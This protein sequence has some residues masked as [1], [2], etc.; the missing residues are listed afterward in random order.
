MGKFQE[1][2]CLLKNKISK[3]ALKD[4][5]ICSNFN[6]VHLVSNKCYKIKRVSFLFFC[7]FNMD[8]HEY[9]RFDD[10]GNV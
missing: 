10:N 5:L 3:C 1:N 6:N 7:F 2:S 8:I 4:F 9:I